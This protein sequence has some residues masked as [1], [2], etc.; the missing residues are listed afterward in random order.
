MIFVGIDVAS[1]KHDCAVVDN[2]GK[3]LAEFIFPNNLDGFG[4]FR[5]KL[6]SLCNTSDFSD[7]QI[8][9]E[10]TGHYSKNLVK[11]LLDKRL[12]VKVFNPLSV[13]RLKKAS[14]LRR[15]KTDKTDARFLAGLLFNDDSK[16]YEESVAQISEL[17]T[18]TR[19]RSR[20]VKESS[21]HKQHISRL[22]TIVFPELATVFSTTSI[23]TVRG[24]LFE[25]PSASD[26]AKADIRRLANVL[27]KASK[28]RFGRDKAEELRAL[29]R[30][31]IGT[32]DRATSFELKQHLQA[33]SFIKGQIA[34]LDAMIQEIMDELDSPI[35]T[36]PGISYTLGAIILAEIGDINN[37]ATPAKLLAYAG[38]DPS[39]YQSGKFTATNT[40]MVKHGSRYLR[41]ALM[42]AATTVRRSSPEF[43]EYFDKKTAEGKH[44]FVAASHTA[45]KLNRVIFHLL[46]YNN[47]Y[48]PQILTA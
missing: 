29:A 10:S 1:A 39:C 3:I 45:K 33:L 34:G 7:I 11:Y 35:V 8:G 47:A 9:L 38:L 16:P 46:K 15:T 32:T 22:I 13:Q 41:Y 14:T 4:L 6:Q 27:W 40:P 5:A 12:S 21:G 42:M 28:H 36:I 44:Y 31:S 20:L 18:L 25:F 37:F 48:K 43:R 26:I 23:A 24:L 19:H 2:S 17:K 30:E